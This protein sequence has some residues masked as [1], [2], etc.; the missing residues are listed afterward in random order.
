MLKTHF[1]ICQCNKYLTNKIT[2]KVNGKYYK[3]TLYEPYYLY[4]IISTEILQNYGNK[5]S[6][7]ELRIKYKDFYWNCIWYFGSQGLSYDMLLK[8]KDEKNQ[9]EKNKKI[10]KKRKQKF[11]CLQISNNNN[12]D[13]LT[14]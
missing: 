5:I 8:Y 10:I 3:I 6:L 2:I 12:T 1:L 11:D 13:N 14:V 9:K 7:D 4:R